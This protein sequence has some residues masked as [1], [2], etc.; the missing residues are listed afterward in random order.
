MLQYTYRIEAMS[1]ATVF[2]WWKHFKNRNESVIDDAQSGRP[3]TA[4]TDNTIKLNSW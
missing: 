1:Q 3:S 4:V 2:Q